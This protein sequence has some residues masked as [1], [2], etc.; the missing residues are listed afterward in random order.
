VF[1]N[2]KRPAFGP[3]VDHRLP[4]GMR[5]ASGLAIFFKLRFRRPGARAENSRIKA[6][7]IWKPWKSQETPKMAVPNPRLNRL[8][9]PLNSLPEPVAEDDSPATRRPHGKVLT[10]VGA[11]SISWIPT[12]ALVV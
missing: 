1:Q 11:I 7:R 3:L 8:V 12:L 10:E 4:A 5:P 6:D 2:V 9:A